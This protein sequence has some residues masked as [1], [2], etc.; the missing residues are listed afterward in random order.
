MIYI[1]V[2]VHTYKLYKSIQDCTSHYKAL[3]AYTYK[4]I[5]ACTSHYKHVEVFSHMYKSLQVCKPL[6]V[7]NSLYKV[8]IGTLNY[9]PVA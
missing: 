5:Q 8:Y 9:K 7:T 6:Q 1:L 4:A 3:Q 2:L